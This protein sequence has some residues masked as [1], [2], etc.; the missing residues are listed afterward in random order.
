MDRRTP[1]VVLALLLA[2]AGCP[3]PYSVDGYCRHIVELQCRFW[4]QCCNGAERIELGGYILHTTQDECKE[5]MPKLSC[6]TFNAYSDAV[7]A[8]RAEWDEGKAKSCAQSM[9]EGASTC[10]AETFYQ[11]QDEDCAIAD[12][13]VGKVSQGGECFMDDE[14]TDDEASCVQE[15]SASPDRVL[16]TAA[17]TCK[18]PPHAG[19]PCDDGSCAD[20]LF[21]DSDDVCRALRSNGE[22]CNSGYECQSGRC[23]YESASGQYVCMAKKP[24]GDTC[25]WY[26][27]CE[28]GNCGAGG[29]CEPKRANGETCDYDSECQSDYCD[30]DTDTCGADPYD[31]DAETDYDICEGGGGGFLGLGLAVPRQ[32]SP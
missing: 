12:L 17:G 13:L 32:P 29:T 9:E 27:E 26:D 15:P 4:Y 25:T 24:N 8:G 31:S 30:W 5:E 21:C 22:Q 16:V 6:G 1:L 14:C 19:E 28:S 23:D 11:G 2:L 20:G 10:S 18:G 7:A 3:G